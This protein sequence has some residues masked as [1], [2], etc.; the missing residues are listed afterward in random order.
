ME[1]KVTY[2]KF[3]CGICDCDIIKCVITSSGELD[4]YKKRAMIDKMEQDH[5]EIHRKS[6]AFDKIYNEFYKYANLPRY[7]K[8]KFKMEK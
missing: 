5:L 8:N 1:D 2:I 3:H 6:H 7:Y 4:P